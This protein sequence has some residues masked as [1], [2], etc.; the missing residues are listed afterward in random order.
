MKRKALLTECEQVISRARGWLRN[1]E[2]EIAAMD[3]LCSHYKAPYLYTVLGERRQARLYADLM[4]RRYLQR[5]GD[6]R[7]SDKQKGWLHLPCSPA[8][9]YVYSNGWLIVGLP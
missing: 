5:N 6:F 1:Q 7:T 2:G 9:R 3:D 8:N 4:G